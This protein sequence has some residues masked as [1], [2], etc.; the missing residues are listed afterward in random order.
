MATPLI[1][2]QIGDGCLERERQA[3]KFVTLEFGLKAIPSVIQALEFVS[4][5]FQQPPDSDRIVPL[6]Y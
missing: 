4:K 6:F 2:S 5:S 1:I 3:Y